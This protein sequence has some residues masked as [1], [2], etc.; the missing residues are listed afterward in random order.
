MK[1]T[2]LL[3]ILTICVNQI[4][5]KAQEYGTGLEFNDNEYEKQ[6][7]KAKLTRSLYGPTLPDKSS[8]KKWAPTPKT[9]GKYSTCVS[10]ATAYA[11]YTIIDNQKKNHTNQQQKD[12]NTYS[13][14]FIYRLISRD[15]SCRTG[16][17]IS[18]ALEIMKSKGVP[19]YKDYNVICA[20]ASVPQHLYSKAT[21]HK[22]KDFA[23]IFSTTHNNDYKIMVTQKALS[24]GKPVVI[25]MST[26]RS[27]YQA[28]GVWQ[29]TE[30]PRGRFGGHAMCVIG[31]DDNKYGGAFEIMNSWGTHWGNGGF[32][33]VKYRD[34]ANFTKYAY[35]MFEF[36][37]R[38]PESYDLSGSFK[39]VL[40][41]GQEM[42]VRK[43]QGKYEV[44][45]AYRSGTQFRLMISNNE[46][47]YVYA[48]GT[49][50]TKSTFQIFPHGK[51]VSPALTY[52]QNNVAIPD[53]DHFI[54]M[55]NTIGTDYMFVL[56]SKK[57][58]NL[59]SIRNKFEKYSG[60]PTQRLSY[61]L[62]NNMVTPSNIESLEGQM[63]FRA[64]SKGK[65]VV[66]LTVAIQHIP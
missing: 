45:Q 8:L 40:S 13:P 66:A 47:A 36:P 55:D 58:L 20:D 32:I 62:G 11:G 7:I 6:P 25:G 29:P 3:L 23:R 26:P 33:W 2:I 31:Y 42:K 56:Y 10:W 54:E 53:E 27:F 39:L 46:P 60:S 65:S 19:T 61:A 1:K 48:F 43:N 50:A 34:Y 49:D 22:I 52:K 17:Y 57:P 21:R 4:N 24:E 9:Q 64:K 44:R 51:Y 30:N 38:K 12:N 16:T 59:N 14:P 15:N 18:K 28:K 63:R 35:E 5:V 41:N 37:K